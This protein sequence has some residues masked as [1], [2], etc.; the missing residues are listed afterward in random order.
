MR[1]FWNGPYSISGGN[2]RDI[3]IYH[4]ESNFL[5]FQCRE[6]FG[7]KWPGGQ[8]PIAQRI[9]KFRLV[10]IPKFAFFL[11]FCFSTIGIVTSLAFLYFNLRFR[12]VKT[13]KLSSPRLNNIVVL[14]CILV[15]IA[16]I[17]LGLDHQA[18][19]TFFNKKFSQLCTVN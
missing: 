12:R 18:L 13:V 4:A 16:V 1:I 17:L 14:G 5:D 15:Y 19:K 2:L 8:I 10:T 6:C 7:I 3:A 9:L 11:V